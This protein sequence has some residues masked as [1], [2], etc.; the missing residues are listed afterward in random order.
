MI[1]ACTI[2]QCDCLTEVKQQI[3]TWQLYSI[4]ISPIYIHTYMCQH[5]SYVLYI[6]YSYIPVY[7]SCVA[8]QFLASSQLLVDTAISQ[9]I[10]VQHRQQ[11]QIYL[12]LILLVSYSQLAIHSQ[13]PIASQP[14]RIAGRYGRYL[15]SYSSVHQI[16]GSPQLQQQQQCSQLVA[17][18]LAKSAAYK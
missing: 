17:S 13:I 14:H 9:R 10:I 1:F 16:L 6:L 8:S 15:A 5:A 3:A 4:S 12:I 18:Y 7:V 2:I 11:Q